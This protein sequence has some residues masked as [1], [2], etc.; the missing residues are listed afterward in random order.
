MKVVPQNMITNPTVDMPCIK[1]IKVGR[2]CTDMAD[3]YA[4]QID[5]CL[6]AVASVEVLEVQSSLLN[7]GEHSL[8]SNDHYKMIYITQKN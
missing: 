8:K 3:M 4:L 2:L 7:K 1:L 6:L 5:F